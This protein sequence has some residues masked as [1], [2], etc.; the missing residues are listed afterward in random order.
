MNPP[1][2]NCQTSAERR[3]QFSGAHTGGV[4]YALGDGQARFISENIDV[5]VFKALLTRAGGEN[6]GKF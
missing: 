5:N 6:P 3:F 1:E 2:T 4:Q